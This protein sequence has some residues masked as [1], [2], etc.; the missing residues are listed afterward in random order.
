MLT[1]AMHCQMAFPATGKVYDECI[2]YV[3]SFL[4]L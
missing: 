2:K 1:L 4:D 3:K